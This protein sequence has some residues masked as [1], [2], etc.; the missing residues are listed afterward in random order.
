VFTTDGDQFTPKHAD[1]ISIDVR[2][3]NDQVWRQV[4]TSAALVTLGGGDTT[5]KGR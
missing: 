1:A 3:N 4:G 2:D 5:N